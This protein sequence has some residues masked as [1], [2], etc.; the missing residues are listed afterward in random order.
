MEVVASGF[1]VASLAIQLLDST[2]MIKKFVRSVKDAPQE[3]IRVVS[4]LD[5]L[6]GLFQSIA[7]T[8]NQQASMPDH[9]VPAPGAIA[10][11]L[12]SCEEGLEPLQKMA[13]KHIKLQAAN[14]L[15]RLRTAVRATLK[16]D[17]L[18][19][20]EMRLHQEITGLVAALEINNTSL[21]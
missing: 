15:R 11:C 1:A 5:R 8:L 9:L 16:A 6:S 13:D 17:D 19:N 20:L 7:N 2:S 14:R 18:R 4:L 21:V 10:K 12:H 3:R